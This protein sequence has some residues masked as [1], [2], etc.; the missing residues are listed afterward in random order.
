MA[1]SGCQDYF[2]RRDT[3]TY[4]VGDAVEVNKTTQTIERW[5][6]AARYDRWPTDG[7]RSRTAVE[8]YRKREVG[9]SG[10]EKAA[11]AAASTTS[12]GP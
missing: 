2:D 12:G 4:G 7:E 10:A 5:P 1:V 6:N 11:A 8:K 3:L 9:K